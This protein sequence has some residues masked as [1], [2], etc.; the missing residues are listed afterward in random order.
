MGIKRNKTGGSVDVSGLT[1]E[2]ASKAPLLTRKTPNSYNRHQSAINSDTLHIYDFLPSSQHAY[3]KQHDIASQDASEVSTALELGVADAISHGVELHLPM[4]SLCYNSE[5]QITHACS[6]K[7]TGQSST[8][9]RP[10]PS[11]Q[12]WGITVDDTW[13]DASQSFGMSINS[14]TFDPAQ[15]RFGVRLKGFSILG[16]RTNGAYQHG[17]RTFQRVDQML[18]DD[19]ALFYL[20]GTGF[21]LGSYGTDGNNLGLVRE[22]SFRDITVRGCGSSEHPS[23]QIG[24]GADAGDGTNQLEFYG[25]KSVY[26]MSS[27][28]I[29]SS[30][31]QIRRITFDN[32]MLHGMD[33]HASAFPGHLLRILGIIRSLSIK[34]LKANGSHNVAGNRYGTIE[35]N[36]SNGFSPQE[37]EIDGDHRSCAGHGY[38]INRGNRLLISGTAQPASIGGNEAI[39]GPNCVAAEGSHYDVT[40]NENDRSILIDPTVSSLI[41]G[42]SARES[43]A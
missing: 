24:S 9:L 42:K 15:T 5:L 37:I 35:I 4:G 33:G 8:Y 17:I 26:N 40:A 41:A 18:W 11:Y 12:G 21:D 28:N 2:I 14:T 7:G 10:H 13:Y 43:F 39:F 30:Q 3:V 27:A 1:S 31:K 36:S 34:K 19:V 16:N 20:N 32:L 6:I 29:V 22:S 25:L 38:V 23:W